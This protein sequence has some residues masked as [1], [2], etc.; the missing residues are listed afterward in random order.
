[1][2][3]VVLCV[4]WGF[5]QPTTVRPLSSLQLKMRAKPKALEKTNQIKGLA[6]FSVCAAGP[7]AGF[8]AAVVAEGCQF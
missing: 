6:A 4:A 3:F 8:G 7:L 1:M 5:L 2:G